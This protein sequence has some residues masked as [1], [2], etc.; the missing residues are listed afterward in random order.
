MLYSKNGSYPS[1]ETDGSPGWIEVPDPPEVP[2][3]KELVWWYPPG[4]VVRD[5]QPEPIEGFVWKWIESDSEWRSYPLS[6][7]E[8]TLE[9][10]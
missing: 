10:E 3:G 8:P 6:V 7:P 1:T 9:S 4:W 2:E 5:P